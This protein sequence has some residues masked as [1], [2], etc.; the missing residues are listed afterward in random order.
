MT[1]YEGMFVIDNRQANRDWEGS[2]EGLKGIL[3][4][5]G[6]EILRCEKWGDRKLAYEIKGRRRGTYVLTYFHA[7]GE[8]VNRIYRAAELSDLLVRALILRVPALPPEEP[9]RPA[10]TEAPAAPGKQPGP[11]GESSDKATAAADVKEAAPDI[12]KEA[13]VGE[14]PST[15]DSP[16][17]VGEKPVTP[18]AEDSADSD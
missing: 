13:D 16:D 3:T 12:E 7:S 17:K 10:T 14:A 8:V 5:Q 1:L 15:D 18:D 9:K 6:A 4:K 11:A 2:L